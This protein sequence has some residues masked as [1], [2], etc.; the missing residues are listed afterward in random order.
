[1]L[2]EAIGVMGKFLDEALMDKESIVG[3]CMGWGRVV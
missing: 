3:L 1:M 2:D